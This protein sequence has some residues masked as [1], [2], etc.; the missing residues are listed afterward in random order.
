LHIVH[1]NLTTTTK[2]GGVETFVWDL[3]REQA[4]AGH[5]VTIVSGRGDVLRDIPGVEV[6]MA[7]YIDRDR[8]SI[9]P[10]RRAWALRKLAERLTMLPRGLFL[11][12]RPDLVHIHKPYDLPLAP[13]LK[14]RG[15]PVFYHGHGEGF[16][17][18]D[19][20][21]AR[22]AAALLSCSTFNA[23]TLRHHYGLE[24]TIVFNGVDVDH[25]RPSPAEPELRRA[26]ADEARHVVLMPGRFMPWKG[27]AYVIDAFAALRD[28][29]ARLVL[30][31]DGETRERLEDQATAL[32]LGDVVLFTGTVPHR[33]MPRYFA[34]ADLVIGASLASETFG[35]VLAEA[36]ACERPV[37]ASSWRGYD[38]V[39]IH[40]QTGE[41]FQAGNPE[42]L[43]AVL[44]RLLNDEGARAAF[45]VAGRQRVSEL[46]RWDKVAA[47]VQG[48]YDGALSPGGK[49]R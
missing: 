23:D 21:L 36:M 22:Q 47:R 14:V 11:I 3:A 8:F 28:L 16:F 9:G 5:R 6:R 7:G 48:V 10:F 24:A 1:Y 33:D 18:G 12:G 25:F 13:L 49:P 19:R 39:V 37:L 29:S 45:G 26:L 32:G 34:A 40:G 42:S 31:G 4:R 2:E 38:D 15:V 44:R 27:H 20:T 30:V 17:P 43:A 41:R 46:F 35:M